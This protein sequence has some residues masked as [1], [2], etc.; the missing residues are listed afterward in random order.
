MG[1]QQQ[2]NSWFFFFM[3]TVCICGCVL[4]VAYFGYRSMEYSTEQTRIRE[5]QETIRNEENNQFWQKAIPWGE[6]ED[7]VEK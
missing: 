3:S 2:D 1:Y 7:E 6:Y 4:A 5:E